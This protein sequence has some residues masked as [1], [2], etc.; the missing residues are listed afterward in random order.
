MQSFSWFG[1]PVWIYVSCLLFFW[2]GLCVF[3]TDALDFLTDNIIASGL[4]GSRLRRSERACTMCER[5]KSP[6]SPEF[7][8]RCI[9]FKLTLLV[10][11]FIWIHMLP[12]FCCTSEVRVYLHLSS[13]RHFSWNASTTLSASHLSSFHTL[14]FTA[15]APPTYRDV[16]KM[17]III[18]RRGHKSRSFSIRWWTFSFLFNMFFERT[19][20]FEAHLSLL[21]ICFFNFFIFD[22][23]SSKEV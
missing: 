6:A 4:C 11:L 14:D 18:I 7:P 21:S 3:L 19:L 22:T 13:C 20:T 23:I 17:Y 5:L 16:W 12:H 2:E 1:T 8:K 10:S 15:S 9:T